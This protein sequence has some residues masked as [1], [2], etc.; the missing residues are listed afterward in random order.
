MMLRGS[1]LRAKIGQIIGG[2]W[3]PAAELTDRSHQ[4]KGRTRLLKLE[5]FAGTNQTKPNFVSQISFKAATRCR[6]RRRRRLGAALTPHATEELRAKEQKAKEE[7]T[8]GK[9]GPASPLCSACGWLNWR[10]YTASAP[11]ARGA[12][13]EASGLALA[14]KDG[15]AS[16]AMMTTTPGASRSS[17]TS[18]PRT[19]AAFSSPP[20]AP[21]REEDRR[22]AQMST[23]S[24]TTMRPIMSAKPRKRYGVG[25]RHRLGRPPPPAISSAATPPPP[26]SGLIT[27]PL[28]L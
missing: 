21:R 19:D 14:R 1:K 11:P 7:Q 28:S 17:G 12:A 4:E 27:L 15:R 3:D 18:T 10:A 20:A 22:R 13:R 25:V 24:A 16:P 6:N 8:L 23:S 26:L 5:A 9:I 2:E